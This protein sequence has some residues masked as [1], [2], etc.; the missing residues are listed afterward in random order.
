M[1]L[2][3]ALPFKTAMVPTGIL[4]PP[5]AGSA[6][7]LTSNYADL[8]SSQQQFALLQIRAAPGNGSSVYLINTSG[9]ADVT[10]FTN[11]L[12]IIP[13]GEQTQINLTP[14]QV[15]LPGQY[16]IDVAKTGDFAVALLGQI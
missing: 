3:N 16:Y 2:P 14:S 8:G 12:D 5:A 15:I 1:A 10:S 9:S 13:P 7:S 11:V 4:K 6:I